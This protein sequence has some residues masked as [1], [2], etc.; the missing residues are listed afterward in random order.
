M[1][2]N[3]PNWIDLTVEDIKKKY[4]IQED[5]TPELEE[6]IKKDNK[7]LFEGISVSMEN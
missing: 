5:L 2:K 6:Q 4:N 1:I 7:Y 3:E